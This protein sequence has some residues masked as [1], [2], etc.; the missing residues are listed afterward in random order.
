MK[1]LNLAMLA[2]AV[3]CH[4]ATPA[5]TATPTSATTAPSSTEAQQSD[6]ASD[7]PADDATNAPQADD[8]AAQAFAKHYAWSQRPALDAAPA[9]G[10]FVGVGDTGKVAEV[11]LKT[12]KD[13]SKGWEL[14][15]KL[16][17][18]TDIGPDL[19][20]KGSG[21][22]VVGR[23]YSITYGAH[24]GDI[25]QAPQDGKKTAATFDKT[26]SITADHAY[27]VKITK[28]ANGKASGR[29]FVVWDNPEYIGGKNA[30]KLWAAG[31]FTDAPV[32]QF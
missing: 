26:I 13:A 11:K 31:T 32:S 23:E 30:P 6:P 1:L 29:L 4:S 21:A 5:A 10:V 14:E 12:H 19:E 28:L 8:A 25:F 9:S 27:V 3:G 17:D 2:F 16:P 20:F 18:D 24:D 7:K 15:A 22:P